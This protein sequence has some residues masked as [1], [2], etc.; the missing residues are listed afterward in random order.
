MDP[1]IKRDR[2]VKAAIARNSS[3]VT[4]EQRMVYAESKMGNKN[5]MYGKKRT[6]EEKEMFRQKSIEIYNRKKLLG[7]KINNSKKLTENQVREIRDKYK[8]KKGSF[9]SLAKEYNVGKTTIEQ[10]V[11]FQKWK[12]LV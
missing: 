5:P 12:D 2:A 7:I 3:V 1:K 8:T 4:L 10:I 9:R 11:T 6:D